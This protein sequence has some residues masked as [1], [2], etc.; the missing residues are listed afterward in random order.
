VRTV[1]VMIVLGWAGLLQA[2]DRPW[3]AD[4]QLV[5]RLAQQRPE[6]NWQEANVPEYQLPD[7]L[8]AA[9]GSTVGNAEQ[10]AQRRD[11]ILSL[12]R[13]QMYGPIAGPPER[14]RFQVE[15]DPQAMAGA[16]TLKRIR[17]LSRHAGREH[18]LEVLLFLPNGVREPVPVF[19]LINNRGRENTDPTRQERSGFW[20]A[21]EVIA[22]GYGI[23][24]F[25]NGELAPDDRQRYHEGVIRLFEGD[26]AAKKRAP[27]A[28][29]ALAAWG[30][31]ASRALDYFETDPRVDA[32]KVA[33]IGHS[34]GGKAA[35]WT[36]A[37]DA[38][39]AVTISN[40][41]GAGGAA[42]SRR[43]FG[44]TV[45]AVNRFTHWFNDNFKTFDDREDQLPF[46]QHLL[47]A[48]IAPRAVCIASADQDLWADPRGEFLALAHASPVYALW[49]H[50]PID[51]DAMPALDQPLVAGP[52]SYHVRTGGHNL[53]PVDWHH[54]MDFTD[55]LWG[56]TASAA[57]SP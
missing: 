17:V 24:A 39:F 46:D 44:E 51:P 43:R 48:L 23:A 20:P 45:R 53:T 29:A 34:R 55:G 42:L 47:V 18:Q 50:P 27:D 3:Q 21:E 8:R 14:L 56:R 4:L 25:Q 36:G 54:Y 12:F 6:Y 37:E 5:E 11:E 13:T 7:P 31:G 41:S 10:W 1:A 33:V 40:N 49:D 28:W 2:D 32:G 19:L 57:A 16:A 30:W 26:A 35:L 15:E 9:D 38:R 52:R 22:R